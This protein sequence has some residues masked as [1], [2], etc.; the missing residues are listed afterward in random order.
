MIESAVQ[1]YKCLPDV[2]F[3][4]KNAERSC[5]SPRRYLNGRVLFS[6]VAALPDVVDKQKLSSV[7]ISE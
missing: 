3:W 5:T 6:V 4:S 1:T 7:M 2:R